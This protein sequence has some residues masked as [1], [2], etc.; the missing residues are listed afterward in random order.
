MVEQEPG[1]GGKDSALATIKRLIGHRVRAVK[2]S[3]DKE[4]RA[5]ELSV[6]VNAGLVWFPEKYRQDGQWAGWCK[7]WIEEAKHFPHSTFKDQVDSAATGFNELTRPKRRIGALRSK[8]ER[9][10]PE[11]FARSRSRFAQKYARQIVLQSSG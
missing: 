8:Q 3:G 11:N 6:A 1:S 9:A 5:D 4:V 10:N 7:E 2:A